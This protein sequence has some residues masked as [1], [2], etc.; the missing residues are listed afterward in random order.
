MGAAL[1]L[2]L[3]ALIAAWIFLRRFAKRAGIPAGEQIYQDTEITESPAPPLRS[4]RLRLLG[5][6]D[7]LISRSEGVVPVEVKHCRC[8]SSG[9][10]ESHLGQLYGYCLLV[11]DALNTIVP[12]GVLRYTDREVRMPFGRQE[13][14]WI[15]EVIAKIAEATRHLEIAPMPDSPQRCR[16]C[17][18]RSSCGQR[19]A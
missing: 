17:S 6:P 8:P 10:Y 4:E 16:S 18:I 11:E 2:L 12:Y 7:Y 15:H 14:D 13:R 3:L 9:P 1:L 19:L 5:R